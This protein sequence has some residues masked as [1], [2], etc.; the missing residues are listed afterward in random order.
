MQGWLW[1]W[2]DGLIL[3]H[4]WLRVDGLIL[5]SVAVGS[6][7]PGQAQD[8]NPDQGRGWAPSVKL[9]KWDFLKKTRL[10]YSKVTAYLTSWVSPLFQTAYPKSS[11]VFWMWFYSSCFCEGFAPSCNRA[12]QNLLDFLLNSQGDSAFLPFSC[13]MA[14]AWQPVMKLL[15]TPLWP[16]MCAGSAAARGL[17]PL[18]RDL[19]PSPSTEDRKKGLN[20]NGTAF[21]HPKHPLWEPGQLFI[22]ICTP[23]RCIQ[24][25]LDPLESRGIKKL[26]CMYR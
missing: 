12:A 4:L 15:Q 19:N 13:S 21:P 25:W 2:G 11:S 24:P 1:G 20:K 26:V 17:Q 5:L 9:S 18:T 3:S 16:Q 7:N 14:G 8:S 22:I 10:V 23:E 6:W